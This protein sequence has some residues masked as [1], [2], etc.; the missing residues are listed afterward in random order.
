[1]KKLSLPF[2]GHEKKKIPISKAPYLKLFLFRQNRNV[3]IYK[4]IKYDSE[5]IATDDSFYVKKDV[6]K[7]WGHIHFELQDLV[8]SIKYLDDTRGSAKTLF[9]DSLNVLKFFAVNF[10]Y[11][12]TIH[13]CL[14]KMISKLDLKLKN[15]FIRW[16]F[17]D[18]RSNFWSYSK[19]K[20]KWNK[21]S[22]KCSLYMSS[23]YHV[24]CQLKHTN[25]TFR[26][27]WR[28]CYSTY[29]I[30]QNIYTKIVLKMH[31]FATL[32]SVARVWIKPIYITWLSLHLS[33]DAIFD[34]YVELTLK[35]K[36]LEDKGKLR[37]AVAKNFVKTMQSLEFLGA[38][39]TLKLIFLTLTTP[40]K[41]F[42][43]VAIN[44]FQIIPNM[45]K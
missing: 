23:N 32:H 39:H 18:C 42:Q 40:S 20:R 11:F 33:V 43:R 30:F 29:S 38:L 25:D 2:I 8:F 21:T 36:T 6:M 24:V 16:C 9:F 1:M 12:K 3:S 31:Q 7:N 19:F 37:G 28:H 41:A 4:K 34:K 35:L 22:D 44:F 10:L 26:C 45:E 5:R 14:I 15:F 17:S 27:S 13:D